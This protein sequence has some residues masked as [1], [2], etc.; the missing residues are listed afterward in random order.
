[1]FSEEI[2]FH[3]KSPRNSGHIDHPTCAIDEHNPSCGDKIHLELRFEDNKVVAVKHISNG[4]AISV[5][6]MSMLSEKLIGMTKKEILAIT[7]DTIYDMLGVE[8]SPG[9]VKCALLSL[10]TVKNALNNN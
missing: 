8:I 9:R 2:L 10:V 5:A 4:C 6:S 7:N 1:M 3:Y